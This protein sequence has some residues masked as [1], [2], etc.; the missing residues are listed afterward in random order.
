MKKNIF[1]IVF[2]V[3]ILVGCA[4][5]YYQKGRDA[6][7][8]SD[9]ET[10]AKVFR[11]LAEQND[12]RGQYALAIMY[13]MGEGVPQNSEKA[14]KY[15]RLAAEQGYADAQNNLGV[16]YDQGEGVSVN[17][18]EAMKWYLLAAEQ[19]NQDA[20]NNIGV[21]HMIGLGVP[22]DFF[23]AHKW[24]SIAGA[25]DFEARSNK[26]FIERRL[27]PEQIAESERLAREWHEKMDKNK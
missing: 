19:G 23:K 11:S 17:Y 25:K 1:G 7:D 15:Y 16:M 24:F 6:F 12:P 9:Y 21:M 27:T 22:R 14:L 8:R 3:C 13:D 10:A 20:P 26:K 18:N 2:A 5:N 4:N